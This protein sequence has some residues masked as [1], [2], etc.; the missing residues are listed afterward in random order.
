MNPPFFTGGTRARCAPRAEARHE[1]TPLETWLDCAVRR[2]APGGQ[3]TLIQAA[4]R[5]PD[6]LR[7][8]DRRMGGLSIRPLAARQGRPA[9]R[10]I[11][12]ARKGGRGPFVLHPPFVLH[13]GPVHD[14]DRDSYTAEAAAILRDGAG[15]S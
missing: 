3:L 15:L 4:D 11:V 9:G 14:G 10:V 8:L 5:L 7:G 12:T 6:V 2:L 13:E 1:E